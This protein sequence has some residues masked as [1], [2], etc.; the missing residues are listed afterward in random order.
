MEG[1]S[2]DMFK[3]IINRNIRP[4]RKL[5]YVKHS[6]G[7]K[8][9]ISICD[10][11]LPTRDAMLD[12]GHHL[13][14]WYRDSFVCN[15]AFFNGSLPVWDAASRYNN[16]LEK[17]EEYPVRGA[18]NTMKVLLGSKIVEDTAEI[19]EFINTGYWTP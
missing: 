18:A 19:Q 9:T 3:R 11:S 2:W 5:R 13:H 12:T 14:D 10:M 7:F 8:D 15:S 17:W 6:C 16:E 1:I 4:W